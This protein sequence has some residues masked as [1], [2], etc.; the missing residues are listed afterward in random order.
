MA[1][2]N[3][4]PE[5]FARVREVYGDW[6]AGKSAR[7]L[8]GAMWPVRR[9]QTADPGVPLLSQATVH[10]DIPVDKQL[11]MI[12]YALSQYDFFGDIFPFY[13][14]DCFGPGIVAAFLGAR[15]DNSTGKVWFHP[16]EK[17]DITKTEFHYDPDNYWLKRVLTLCR[18][19][20]DRFGGQVIFGMPDLGGILD[21]LS[22][23]FPGDELL[24][25]LYD[26]PEAV[27]KLAGEVTE[28]WLRYYR[29]IAAAIN[30]EERG[31]SDW[32]WIYSEKPS[33]VSQCDFSYMIGNGFFKEFAAPSLERVFA[34][35]D[36]NIYHLDGIGELNHLDTLLAM[37]DLQAIQWV[38]GTGQP[39]GSY[40][41]DV[42]RRIA[43]KGRLMQLL[44]FEYAEADKIISAVGSPG[45]FLYFNTSYAKAEEEKVFSFYKRYN[46]EK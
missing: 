32:S 18:A 33:Y 37:P 16:P 31:Y 4:T 1:K 34:E 45:K 43:A 10:L 26:E 7:P 21:I 12:E 13:N 3:F 20:S 38:S 8:A 2:I 15:L 23:F 17:L 9:P 44:A 25:L 6:W 24:M 11:D 41:T 27:K 22:S 5:R 39:D 36:N 35:L 29:E 19:A 30:C 40:W 14:L 28:L 46:I 42:Y